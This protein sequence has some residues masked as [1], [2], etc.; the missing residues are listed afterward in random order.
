MTF[1][2]NDFMPFFSNRFFTQY[3]S[4]KFLHLNDNAEATLVTEVA[5]GVHSDLF[6]IQVGWEENKRSGQRQ[7]LLKALRYIWSHPVIKPF[8]TPAPVQ[9]PRCRGLRTWKTECHTRDS[10]VLRCK[11]GSN[12][13][14]QS[15]KRTPSAEFIRE[16][17]P[18]NEGL[19]MKKTEMV[20][21]L[22]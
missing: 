19:W 7:K 16:W 2:S 17:T 20:K 6:C 14:T 4:N 3:T 11:K 10:V 12:C 9:C 18:G 1:A 15:F 22:Q 21:P 8:G 5:L 13:F